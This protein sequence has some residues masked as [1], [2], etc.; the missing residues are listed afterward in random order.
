L[1]NFLPIT[2]YSGQITNISV[3]N[4]F[5]PVTSRSGAVTTITLIS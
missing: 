1:Y 5:L 3:A 4:G 2:L